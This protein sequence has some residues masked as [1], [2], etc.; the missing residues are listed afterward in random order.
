MTRNNVR[1]NSKEVKAIRDHEKIGLRILLFVKKS[2]AEG[3]DFYYM[4]DVVP[5]SPESMEQTTIKDDKGKERPIVSMIFTMETPVDESLYQY[6][7][8]KR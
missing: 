1:L 4:G 2:D 5:K 6:F 7:E 3:S 8:N